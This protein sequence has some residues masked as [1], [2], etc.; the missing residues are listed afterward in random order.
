[1][2]S[3]KPFYMVLIKFCG[4]VVAVLNNIVDNLLWAINIGVLSSVIDQP[5]YKRWKAT[6]YS[7]DL[8]RLL[9]KLL[10][11]NFGFQIKSKDMKTM[12]MRLKDYS[13]DIIE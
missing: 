8:L 13:D 1:M 2:D 10:Y 6:K 9:L 11:Y 12:L 4:L 5:T 3:K 7:T